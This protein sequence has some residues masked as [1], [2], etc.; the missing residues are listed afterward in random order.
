MWIGLQRTYTWGS[1]Q[2]TDGSAKVYEAPMK[3]DNNDNCMQ[4]KQVS[5]N[6]DAWEEKGCSEEKEYVCKIQG[7]F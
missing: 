2:W 3:D 4:L 6:Q 7:K 1:W 5:S